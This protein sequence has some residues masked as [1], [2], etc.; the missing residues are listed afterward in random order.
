MTK[1]QSSFFRIALSD[2][3]RVKIG[4]VVVNKHHIISSGCNSK[5]RT[6]RI[7]SDYNRKRFDG[8]SPGMLHAEVSALLPLINKVDLSKATIYVYREYKDGT[9]GMCRPCKA[10]MALIKEL[11]IRKIHYT[12]VDGYTEEYIV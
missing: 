11:G 10:C 7:Q 2:F 8:Y 12:T 9:L 6:H 4:A 1:T 5:Q 3:P